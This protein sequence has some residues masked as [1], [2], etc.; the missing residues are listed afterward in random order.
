MGTNNGDSRENLY[1]FLDMSN[2]DIWPT[3]EEQVAA[4]ARK[5]EE[6]RWKKIHDTQA[7]C[8][9]IQQEVTVGQAKTP[10]KMMGKWDEYIRSEADTSNSPSTPP[11]SKTTIATENNNNNNVAKS[12][13]SFLSTLSGISSASAEGLT[14][15]SMYDGFYEEL[16]D[17][18]KTELENAEWNARYETIVEDSQSIISELESYLNLGEDLGGIFGE[19]LN[20]N[21]NSSMEDLKVLK[22]YLSNNVTDVVSSLEDIKIDLK[23]IDELKKQIETKTEEIK[24][25][26]QEVEEA[27][28]A[29]SDIKS[30]E[31]SA[32]IIGTD[33]SGKTFSRPN[34]KHSSWEINL[35]NAE[36]NLTERN[37]ELNNLK[38]ELKELQTELE[39]TIIDM[40]NLLEKIRENDAIGITYSER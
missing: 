2:P 9:E 7:K 23:K 31:P 5:S 13:S 39:N 19:L 36:E 38:S 16:D 34:P 3:V 28:K 10:D 1:S 37:N 12:A 14:D 25:K 32:T 33:S 20:T 24:L 22:E 30:N 26:L 40:A 21:L 27:E 4:S 29:L 8:F 17:D 18:D 11:T 35:S 6:E 15:L